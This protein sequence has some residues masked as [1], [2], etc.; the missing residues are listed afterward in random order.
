MLHGTTLN[1][2]CG[3]ITKN[4]IK[5]TA[6]NRCFLHGA[7][8]HP[9]PVY[10]YKS[11]VFGEAVRFHRFNERK[12]DYLKSLANLKDKCFRLNSNQKYAE[13]M[14]RI[15]QYCKDCF[16]SKS[17]VHKKNRNVWATL[18]TKLFQLSNQENKLKIEAAIEYKNSFTLATKLK[19]YKKFSQTLPNKDKPVSYPCGKRTL[20]GNFKNYKNMVETVGSVI[21]H[22][23]NK[24]F[25][26]KQ[27]LTRKKLWYLCGRV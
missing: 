18:F 21:S 24:K 2:K 5:F 22:S 17:Q 19:N 26:L 3:F 9:T 23:N 6:K 10:L 16:E 4:F 20:C 15:A 25:N 11:I 12:S 8:H 14:L 13:N 7:L 27:H 1:A